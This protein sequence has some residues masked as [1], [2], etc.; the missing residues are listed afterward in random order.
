MQWLDIVINFSQNNANYDSLERSMAPTRKDA[1]PPKPYGLKVAGIMFF[2]IK[3]FSTLSQAQLLSYNNNVSPALASIIDRYREWFLDVNTWGDAIITVSE[4]PVKI[5]RLALDLRDYFRVTNFENMSLPVD[6]KCRISLHAGT[7]N[8]CLD[9]IRQCAGVVGFNV[10]LAA[11]V[12]PVVVP[13]EVWATEE[14]AKTLG[15]HV[16]AERLAFDSIGS[17]KLYKNFG[18][19][20]VLKLRRYDEVLSSSYNAEENRNINR[21][22]SA[23][24]RYFDVVGI[25]ALNTDYIATATNLKKIKPDLISEHEHFF[26]VGKERV[27]KNN[28]VREVISK[29]GRNLLTLS[30]GGSSFNTIHALARAVPE[31]KLAYVG[32]AGKSEAEIGF[33]D[34]CGTVNIDTNYIKRSE[35]DSGVCVSYI[36]RGERSLLTAPGANAEISKYLQERKGEI[37]ELLGRTKVLHITS[38]F[39]EDSP[40]AI[41]SII[42]EAKDQNPWLQ[43]SFDPGYDWVRRIKSGDKSWFIQDIMEMSSY[44]FLNNTE[45]EL[46]ASDLGV[47]DD[48]DLAQEIFQHLS[49]QAVLILL[50]KYNEIKIYHRLHKK[51]KEIKYLNSPLSPNQIE[52]A[53]GAGDVF[54]AGIFVAIMTPGLELR[55]GVELGLRM[56]NKKLSSPGANS[57]FNI[58]QIVDDYV[59]AKYNE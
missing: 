18:I 17:K 37:I 59:N 20:R 7:V 54:A 5:A 56:A 9:S 39:D 49:P 10:N 4:D 52:D 13:G 41:S 44:I 32:V 51:I 11:R 23:M 45:F 29:I 12:E 38:L 24:N 31:L 8:Y 48:Q 14:F 30:L 57:Y 34:L 35:S 21:S 22:I 26:E 58:S 1:R 42:R 25:G 19:H 27:A 16:D 43:V 53:T 6:L 3:N 33:A 2:D 46:L 55:D 47:Q 50:K 40:E 15:P 36:T 28:E